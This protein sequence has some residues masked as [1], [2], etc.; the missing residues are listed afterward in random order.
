MPRRRLVQANAVLLLALGV[1]TI[2]AA[3]EGGPAAGMPADAQ[4]PAS[5]RPRGEYTMISGRIQGAT[6]N[7]VY[8]LDANNQELVALSWD[9]NRNRF[10]GIGYRS[11]L[12]DGR[13]QPAG[14]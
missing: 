12:A 6:T 11:L 10:V 5:A 8:I 13:T 4:P 1:L 9:R 3:M 14:R 7:A 2:A